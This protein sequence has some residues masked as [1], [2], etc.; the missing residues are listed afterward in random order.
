LF[1]GKDFTLARIYLTLLFVDG[2]P[3][4]SSWQRASVGGKIAGISAA[5]ENILVNLPS[6]EKNR[7]T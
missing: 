3:H 7:M 1:W 6:A 4:I 5:F 2:L